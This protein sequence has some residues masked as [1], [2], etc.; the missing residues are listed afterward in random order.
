MRKPHLFRMTAAAIA[1]LTLCSCTGESDFDTS[2]PCYFT[3]DMTLH[4]TGVIKD[5]MASPGLFAY[6]YRQTKN[7]VQYVCAQMNDGKTSD[8]TAITTAKENYQ[9]WRLGVGNGLIVGCSTFGEAYAFD[10]QCPNCTT[11]TTSTG[12]PLTWASSGS[13]VECKKCGCLYQLNNNGYV[14]EG[15]G[16]KLIKYHVTYTGSM[17]IVSN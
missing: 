16:R 9:N 15:E 3:Y 13:Q 2:Y 14:V 5:V 17:L 8:Q 11:G 7:G 4:N 1:L 10:H 12:A 6:V